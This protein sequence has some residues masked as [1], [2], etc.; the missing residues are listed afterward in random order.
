MFTKHAQQDLNAGNPTATSTRRRWLSFTLRTLIL[1][2][3]IC[4][5]AAGWWTQRGRWWRYRLANGGDPA[6]YW[7]RLL[8]L[9]ETEQH[10]FEVELPIDIW[11]GSENGSHN[12][13]VWVRGGNVLRCVTP[14]GRVMGEGGILIAGTKPEVLWN[15]TLS[16]HRAGIA[17][18]NVE[19]GDHYLIFIT[20]EPH[21]VVRL[22]VD[23][24]SVDVTARVIHSEA[25]P[26]LE[27]SSKDGSF[28]ERFSCDPNALAKGKR[29]AAPDQTLAKPW[30]VRLFR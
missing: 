5:I 21:P 8:A 18:F 11:P 6:I 4:A 25:P 10:G 23:V 13:W 2:V 24:E 19:G 9:S 7:P 1:I 26:V 22:L 16:D 30:S 14:D 3:V 12:G 17:L 20:A 29:R 15:G 27:L 28:V